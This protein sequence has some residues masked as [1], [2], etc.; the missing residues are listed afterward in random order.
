MALV[1]GARA[2]ALLLRLSS[3]AASRKRFFSASAAPVEKKP[4]ETSPCNKRDPISN[5]LSIKR[6]LEDL[7]AGKWGRKVGAVV[8]KYYQA[9]DR[10]L[11]DDDTRVQWGCAAEPNR[12]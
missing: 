6:A 1:L 8:D 10:R 2:S 12:V 7:A 4:S 9:I 3:R 5:F 11:D